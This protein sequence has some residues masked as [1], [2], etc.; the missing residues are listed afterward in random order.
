MESR[1]DY[2]EGKKEGF[3]QFLCWDLTS[4]CIFKLAC[5]KC[6]P[7]LFLCKRLFM[8]KGMEGPFHFK[9][10]VLL[11][12]QKIS[13]ERKIKGEGKSKQISVSGNRD[14]KTAFH[15]GHELCLQ[16]RSTGFTSV[17]SQSCQGKHFT[18]GDVA[19]F[20]VLVICRKKAPT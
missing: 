5:C 17:K 14:Y 19:I 8:V 12:Y 2:I 11:I 15:T 7:G 18:C 1:I 6:S 9:L 20:E 4:A 13:K 16:V 10:P 3:A